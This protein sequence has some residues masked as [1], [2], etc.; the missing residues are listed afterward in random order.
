MEREIRTYARS[1]LI[2]EAQPHPCLACGE[3]TRLTFM[4]PVPYRREYPR[5]GTCCLLCGL[6]FVGHRKPFLSNLRY[7]PFAE[8]Q[9]RMVRPLLDQLEAIR[10]SRPPSS[11]QELNMLVRAGLKEVAPRVGS[12]LRVRVVEKLP[13]PRSEDRRHWR[14]TEAMRYGIAVRTHDPVHGMMVLKYPF[15]DELQSAFELLLERFPHVIQWDLR[16]IPMEADA[17]HEAVEERYDEFRRSMTFLK[18]SGTLATQTDRSL[19]RLVVDESLD[20]AEKVRSWGEVFRLLL[21]RAYQAG[22]SDFHIE[23]MTHGNR[24]EEG[25]H[26]VTRILWRIDGRLHEVRRFASDDAWQE[27]INVIKAHAGFQPSR[28]Q[29]ALDGSFPLVV[30]SPSG[31]EV[32]FCRV[33]ILPTRFREACVIRILKTD[34]IQRP[35]EQLGL[36]GPAY[37]RLRSSLEKRDWGLVVLSG[38]T[39]SGKSTTLHVLIRELMERHPERK[40]LSVEDPVEYEQGGIVQ[41]EVTDRF[42]FS[43]A[44]AAFMRHDP[45]VILVGE[46]RDISTAQVTMQLALTGH[47]VL[48]TIHAAILNDILSRFD[49]FGLDPFMVRTNLLAL[50]SQRLVRRPCGNCAVPQSID[51]V[52]GLDLCRI[53]ESQRISL[54]SRLNI[55]QGCDECRGEGMVSRIAV[56]EVAPVGPALWEVMTQ[57]DY[58]VERFVE[59]ARADGMVTFIDDVIQKAA[60]GL[61]DGREV[62]RILGGCGH[63]FRRGPATMKPPAMEDSWLKRSGR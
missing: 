30:Q 61:V 38:P 37:E 7:S 24:R 39:G 60:C 63:L 56:L 25:S 53:L 31:H 52:L 17:Y 22:A 59:A 51:R 58:R 26:P 49:A 28:A 19:K 6:H 23:V 57:R 10:G 15:M 8:L 5:Q 16:L 55:G 54:P 20:R 47:L 62:V 35:R 2:L 40:Y 50:A 1:A 36:V 41:V 32:I 48:T 44:V 46:I 12:W 43:D 27:M 33:N 4:R 11:R 21:L 9:S 29:A 34:V 13:E 45:D 42:G 3:P 14:R 18:D